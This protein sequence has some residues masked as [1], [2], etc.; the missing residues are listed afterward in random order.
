MRALR[1]FRVCKPSRLTLADKPPAGPDSTPVRTILLR[2]QNARGPISGRCSRLDFAY[3]SC[4]CSTA[5]ARGPADFGIVAIH[6]SAQRHFGGAGGVAE[7]AAPQCIGSSA[8][9]ARIVEVN[10]PI[11]AEWPV[12]QL[13]PWRPL[14]GWPRRAISPS[15]VL[16][17]R[18][19]ARKG[20]LGRWT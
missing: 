17:A 19:S 7:V 14:P 1:A 15:P 2:L 6:G 5:L 18:G 11:R 13:H 10:T 8:L 4:G 9:D 12:A 16:T 3:L 20:S